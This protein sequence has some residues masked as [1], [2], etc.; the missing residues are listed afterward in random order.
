LMIDAAKKGLGIGRIVEPMVD[1]LFETGELVPVLKE[2]WF[3]YSG[4]FMYF[5]Q[6]S[7]KAQ[8]IRA[9]IDFL[10]EKHAVLR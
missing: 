1:E 3:P 6:H 9:L 2:N 7:Q 5:Q 8:R 10:E 4:L